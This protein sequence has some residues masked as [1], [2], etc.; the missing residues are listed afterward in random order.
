[1]AILEPEKL[2]QET[3]DLPSNLFYFTSGMERND[4]GWK[5]IGP[6]KVG[7]QPLND[8]RCMKFWDTK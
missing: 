5:P 4:S 1:M 7:G 6:F 2:K 3:R 8:A